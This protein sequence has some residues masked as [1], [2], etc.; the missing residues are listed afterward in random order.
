MANGISMKRDESALVWVGRRKEGREVG[1]KEERKG[2]SVNNYTNATNRVAW[3]L[4]RNRWSHVDVAWPSTSSHRR[5][6]K[7]DFTPSA[8]A[9]PQPY[10]EHQIRIFNAFKWYSI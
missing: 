6:S 5:L 8:S 7:Y 4:R 1:G 10:I 2:D 9:C 3:L